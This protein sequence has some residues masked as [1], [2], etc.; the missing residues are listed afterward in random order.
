M[1]E[2][3]DVSKPSIMPSINTSKD[4]TT[5]PPVIPEEPVKVDASSGANVYVRESCV[6]DVVTKNVERPSTE[7][8]GASIDP[9]VNDTLDG[10]KDSTPLE[11]D[12]LEL[13]VADTIDEGMDAEIPCV[14]DTEAETDGNLERPYAGHG[15]DDTLDDDI[16]EVIPEEAGPKKKYKKRK[17]R[18]SANA[19]E[20]SMPMKKLSKEEK[21]A[22]K[23]RKAERRARRVAQEV[24]DGEVVEDDVPKE[25][26]PS[27]PQ[28]D[29]SD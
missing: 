11:G 25:V 3:A 18:K 26:R 23:A 6:E 2:G 1:S 16:H 19:D 10:L 22:K 8:L 7:G 14:V 5:E 27:V 4:K 24:A 29:V 17:H 9:S 13:S 12:V 15:V 21:A 20:S 28:P